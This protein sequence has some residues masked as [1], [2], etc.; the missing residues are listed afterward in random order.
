ML[1]TVKKNGRVEKLLPGATDK[2]KRKEF[3]KSSTDWHC[4]VDI[5]N[6]IEDTVK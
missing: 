4:G 1:N 2:K 5:K 6:I 3:R